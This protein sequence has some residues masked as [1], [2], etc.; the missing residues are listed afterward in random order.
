M[1]AEQIAAALLD[2]ITT[3]IDRSTPRGRLAKSE[4][5]YPPHIQAYLRYGRYPFN[6][7]IEDQVL[8]LA[9]I[10]IDEICRSRG[11]LRQV[12]DGLDEMSMTCDRL[13]F[14]CVNEPV[15]AEALMRRGYVECTIRPL[16]Y[17][18]RM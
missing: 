6:G 18:K 14:E 11:I 1:N 16:T 7:V 13:V 9:M 2:A 15:L 3:F 5:I 10:E 12:L 17:G 4:H 8:V